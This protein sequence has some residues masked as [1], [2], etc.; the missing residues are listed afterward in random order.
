MTSRTVNQQ[1]DWL[2]RTRENEALTMISRFLTWVTAWRGMQPF[3]AVE[4]VLGREFG[5][6]KLIEPAPTFG[7]I[8]N[9]IR[10]NSAK[11]LF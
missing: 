2:E 4:T 7:R 6:Q 8:A 1:H 9:I 3:T 11:Q 10:E 5:L